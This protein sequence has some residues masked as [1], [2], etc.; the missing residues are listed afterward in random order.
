[1]AI[2]A[3]ISLSSG[4][5]GPGQSVVSTVTV[6]NQSATAVIVQGIKGNLYTSGTTQAKVS[7]WH[8]GYPLG[9]GMTVSVPPNGSVAFQG[10]VCMLGTQ[11]FETDPN[12]DMSFTAVEAVEVLS[13]LSYDV[14]AYVL[15]SDGATT[16]TPTAQLLVQPRPGNFPTLAAPQQAPGQLWFQAAFNSD[17]LPVVLGVP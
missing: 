17:L 3:A 12:K 1:M 6:Y 2:L 11:V 8:D 9:P 10:N 5:T 13:T 4:V 14:S 16:Y 7:G 15:T